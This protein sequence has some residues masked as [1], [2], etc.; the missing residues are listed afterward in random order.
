MCVLVPGGGGGC[1]IVYEVNIV[2]IGNGR[3]D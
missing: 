2:C 3:G 1:D